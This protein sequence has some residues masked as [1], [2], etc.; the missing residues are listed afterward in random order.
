MHRFGTSLT[1]FILDEF[2]I[3]I[4]KNYLINYEQVPRNVLGHY[5]DKDLV[6]LNRKFCD[7]TVTLG[8]NLLISKLVLYLEN[9]LKEKLIRLFP[10]DLATGVSKTPE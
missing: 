10:E 5:E 8:I 1:S 3:N 7:I 6:E 9:S 4:G 2:G